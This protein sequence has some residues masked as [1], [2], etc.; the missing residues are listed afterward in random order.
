MIEKNISF[1]DNSLSE[2]VSGCEQLAKAV[3]STLGANGQTVIIEDQFG[4]PHVTKDGVTVANSI[5]LSEPIQNLGVSIM[6]QASRKTADE[7][8]DGTTTSCALAMAMIQNIVKRLPEI[9]NVHEV[10]R[11]ME[12][13][14][15]NVAMHLKDI[16]R[17]VD[18]LSLKQVATVSANGDQAL[19]SLIAQAYQEVGKNGVVTMED[20]FEGRDVVESVLGTRIKR[21]YGTPFSVNNIRKNTVEYQNPLIVLSDFKIDMH[22][23]LHFAFEASIK[24]KRPL[25][26]I[27]DLDD[28]VKLFLTQNLNKKNLT[29][30]FFSPEGIGISRFELL[31]D[32]ALMTGAKVMSQMSGDAVQNINASYLG[33]C[34]KMIS[35][36]SE[37]ILIF[38]KERDET[39][40]HQINEL[41][42]WLEEEIKKAPQHQKYH[43]E[44]RLS[45]LSGG[46]A[47]IKVHANSEVELKEKKDRVEDSIHA[48]KAALLQGILPGGGAALVYAHKRLKTKNQKMWSQNSDSMIGFEI[49]YESILAPIKA[50]L[51]NSNIDHGVVSDLM[52]SSNKTIGYDVLTK[53]KACM[54]KMG[55][56]DPYKV[57]TNAVQNAASVAATILTTSCVIS[58]KRE[59]ESNR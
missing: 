3:T 17:E 38:D 47:S 57:T 59:N 16:S 24:Q 32:L 42:K 49:I 44:D 18:D 37:T 1:R 30:N 35:N 15:E 43:Y 45:K 40:Q 20:S 25:L 14:A 7:A 33:T 58:N 50:I 48:T 39:K 13:T 54:F 53:R 41:V 36:S 28:R 6:R 11:V 26:I 52:K 46:V 12:I 22:E 2:L 4:N 27:A 34:E 29:A 21:G 55:I 56:V 19:G 31:E 8:G 23:R 10:K 51:D 9:N 5:L